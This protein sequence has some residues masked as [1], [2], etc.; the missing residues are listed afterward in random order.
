M[1]VFGKKS[2]TSGLNRKCVD[3]RNSYG[4]HRTREVRL[5]LFRPLHQYIWPHYGHKSIISGFTGS[6]W[7][8]SKSE[9]IISFSVLNYPY[10][11]L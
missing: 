10:I 11:D 7:A 5:P 4:F 2:I 6:A 1:A 9:V 8:G 3:G